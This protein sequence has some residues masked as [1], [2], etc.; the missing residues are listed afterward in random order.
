MVVGLLLETFVVR[1]LLVPALIALFGHASGWPGRRLA[2]GAAEP[3]EDEPFAQGLE[4]A[5]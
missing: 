5:L 1:S 2:A 4:G 3:A